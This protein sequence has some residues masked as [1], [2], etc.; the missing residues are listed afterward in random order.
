MVPGTTNVIVIRNYLRFFADIE[1]RDFI[2]RASFFYNS[3]YDVMHIMLG[4]WFSIWFRFNTEWITDKLMIWD[5]IFGIFGMFRHRH[6][7]STNMHYGLLSLRNLIPHISYDASW[8]IIFIIV[9]I[10]VTCR[11]LCWLIHQLEHYFTNM[12]I[13]MPS[14]GKRNSN[15][16]IRAVICYDSLCYFSFMMLFRQTGCVGMDLPQ[17]NRQTW[18]HTGDIK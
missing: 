7:A 1:F 14:Q 11:P 18:S 17:L 15:I 4:A 9:L 6:K 5:N 8:L 10:Q 13:H 16:S 2:W 12:N 3:A